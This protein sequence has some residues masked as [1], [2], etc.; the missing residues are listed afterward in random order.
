M[1]AD[2]ERKALKEDLI[3][4]LGVGYGLFNND[5]WRKIISA[6]LRREI[7]GFEFD[8]SSRDAL[9][10]SVSKFLSAV[11]R[12]LEKRFYDENAGNIAGLLKSGV[13][14]FTGTF[15]RIKRD[16]PIFSDQ[17]VNYL[18]APESK[19]A[20]Q[21]ILVGKVERYAEE[22]LDKVDYSRHDLVLRKYGA[23]RRDEA[24]Q[25]IDRQLS[26]AHY[27]CA[28]F[29]WW[30]VG[31]S[32]LAVF[33]FVMLGPFDG[34]A[35][36]GSAIVCL[37]LLLL[38]LLLPMIEIDARLSEVGFELLG[39]R[40]EFKN[41]VLFYK[42]KSV[43][44]VVGLMV[45]EGGIG[46]RLVGTLIFAFSVVFPFSKIACLV[47]LQVQ[48]RIQNHAVVRWV[49]LESG[50]WSMA[51]VMTIAIFMSYVGFSGILNE[52]LG[53]LETLGPKVQVVTTNQS[54]LQAGFFAFTGFV[55][56][57]LVLSAHRGIL[58][59]EKGLFIMTRTENMLPK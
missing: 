44:E 49:A 48:S 42:S 52:Q 28:L 32:V 33:L 39:S 53:Q 16:V 41:Q 57:G 40:A 19:R 29:G 55:V 37:V 4:L 26:R 6:T 56:F 45:G 10:A 11:I 13:A 59:R 25:A 46:S 12:D 9:R 21:E 47:L 8:D 27:L 35:V 23:A 18:T 58:G 43:L 30:V 3:E 38:G 1:R 36:S 14:G 31:M 20:V 50:K 51:D 22:K 2:F 7:E 54:S 34:V 15:E 24:I 5:E 17:V